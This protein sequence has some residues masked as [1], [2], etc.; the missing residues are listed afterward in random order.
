[1]SPC[2]KLR[3]LLVRR[4]FILLL[5]LFSIQHQ[6]QI[7]VGVVVFVHSFSIRT[8]NANSHSIKIRKQQLSSSSLCVINNKKQRDNR[9]KRKIPLFLSS[10]R[11]TARRQRQQRFMTLLS[12]SKSDDDATTN[13]SS[14]AN[15]S[16]NVI[17][18]SKNVRFLGCGEAAIVRP[19]VVLLA[20]RNEYNHYYRNSAVFI[21]AMGERE[22]NDEEYVI[23]G[24]IIDFPTP[25]TL[26]EMMANDN[27][28]SLSGSGLDPNNPLGNNLM[29]RGGDTG[30]VGVILLHDNHNNN[31]QPP[32]GNSGIYQGGWEDA[33]LACSNNLASASNYKVFFNYLEFTENEIDSLLQSTSSSESS[34]P[35]DWCSVEVDSAIILN[36]DWDRGDCWSILRNIAEQQYMA[37]KTV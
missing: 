20:P 33:I 13:G 36:N 5:L 31:Q 1:M 23:R 2:Y 34:C 10:T 32:I 6:Q 3:M 7:N 25:F 12:S 17:M 21:F 35:N 26:S 15:N 30:G 22:D 11:S 14:N 18:T 8:G 28:G 9:D 24:V 29:F 19:G 4:V 27:N 16:N 37:Q